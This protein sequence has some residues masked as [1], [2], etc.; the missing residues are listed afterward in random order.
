MIM[1]LCSVVI[2]LLFFFSD[3]K[4][5]SIARGNFSYSDKPKFSPGGTQSTST[6]QPDDFLDTNRNSDN[7]APS[8]FD[9]VQRKNLLNSKLR[10]A[11]GMFII[12]ILCMSW[13]AFV[14]LNKY[15]IF[16]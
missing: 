6:S 3:H 10:M 1:I 4:S 13:Q 2:W 12:L 16:L 5:W 7:S 14:Y 8:E 11:G 9:M 15:L